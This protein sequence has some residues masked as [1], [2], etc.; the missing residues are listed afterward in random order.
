M[1]PITITPGGGFLLEPTG[2]AVIVTAES[3][4]EDRLL[5]KQTADEFMRR[6][7]DPRLE[8]IEEKKPGVLRELLTK[9]GEVGLLGHDVPEEYGG[10]GGDKLSSS[11]ISE[12]MSRI[13]SWAVTFGCHTGIGTMPVVLF[14]N[15]EQRARYLPRLATGELVAAYAL[16][17]PT[18]GSDALAAKT[19]ARL[20]ADGKHYRLDGSKLYITNG[21]I[22]D[23]YTVFAKVDGDAFTAFLVDRSTPGLTVGAEEHKLGIRGSSTTA[24]FFDGCLV[25]VENLLGA[26]GKGHKIAFNI[27]NIGRYKL[28]VGAL[29]GAKSCLE[30]GIRFAKERRQ[31][32]KPIAE[33][34][35][36][37][38]KLGGI[39]TQIFVA[40]SMAYRTVGLIDARIAQIEEGAAD[41]Q[42]RTIDAIEEHSIEASIIKVFGSEMLFETAD[43]TLQVFGGAGFI[44]DYPIERIS[45]DS[46]IFRIFEGTNEINRLLVPGTLL[47]RA[48]QG[49]LGLMGLLPQIQAEL[50]DPPRISRAVPPGP[51]GSQQ[52]KVD[53]AKRAVG[54]GIAKGV[55]RYMQQIADKQELLGVLADGLILVYAMDSAV[56]RALQLVAERGEAAAQ[57]PIAMTQL[58]VA[59]A[60]ERVFDLVREMLMWMNQGATWEKD[61]AEVNQYYELTR[62]NTFSLRRQIARHVIDRDGYALA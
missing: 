20:T 11:L 15:A 22:A 25:P 60:H 46:R 58:F 43:E 7:V 40:E 34:D 1:A 24:L 39:A 50:A 12:S 38:K 59:T 56:T 37:R 45:R 27:L 18:A 28:G 41:A 10:L 48:M 47:K 4:G 33:F 5:M 61:L 36:I 35:L 16:T 30:L 23:L 2:S 31:F 54:Y 21:G 53:R 32:D 17:E 14:G 49:R 55:E 3:L 57:I 26:I 44:A 9:A 51:L 13:G 62:V 42:R 52:Q 29:G 19:T 6:E 8:D